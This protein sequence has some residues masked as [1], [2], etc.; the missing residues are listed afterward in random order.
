MVSSRLGVSG[1]TGTLQWRILINPYPAGGETRVDKKQ[2]ELMVAG[3]GIL[4]VT[5]VVWAVFTVCLNPDI[6]EWSCLCL[7]PSQSQSCLV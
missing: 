4:S 3:S 1:G 2:Q 6:M 7:D 5:A